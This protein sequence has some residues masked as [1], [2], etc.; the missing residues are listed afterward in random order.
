[1]C[2]T[3][4]AMNCRRNVPS[5]NPRRRANIPFS[6]VGP[7]LY[8]DSIDGMAERSLLIYEKPTLETVTV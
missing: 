3:G 4:N 5:L 6:L 8:K 7:E 1:M 2:R